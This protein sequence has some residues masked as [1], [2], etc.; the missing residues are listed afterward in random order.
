MCPA[1]VCVCLCVYLPGGSILNL[2]SVNNVER[3]EEE[4]EEKDGRGGRWSLLSSRR[5][6]RL[7]PASIGSTGTCFIVTE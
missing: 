3:Q 7:Y 5:R 6:Q 1:C 4:E 2:S